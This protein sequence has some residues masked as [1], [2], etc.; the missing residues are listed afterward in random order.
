M[1]QMALV[2]GAAGVIGKAITRQL[3]EH[4]DYEVV[5]TCR[6]RCKKIQNDERCFHENWCYFSTNRIR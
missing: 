3:P 5:L 2:T 1:N 6:F 4:A